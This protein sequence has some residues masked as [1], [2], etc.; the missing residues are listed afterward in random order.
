[1]GI[2][3]QYLTLIKV[4]PTLP[5][6]KVLEIME[7]KY[8]VCGECLHGIATSYGRAVS[9]F[10]GGLMG[11]FPHCAGMCSPFVLAQAGSDFSVRKLS[12]SLLLPYH[13]GR[14][15]TYVALAVLVSSFVNLAFVFSDLKSLIAVPMLV[16]AG[17]IFMV[18]IFPRTSALFP[19]IGKI[20]WNAP[21]TIV[22]KFMPKFINRDNIF[23]RYALGI[24]LGFMP[25]G[26]V[27]AALMASATAPTVLQAALAMAAFTV[28]TMPALLLVGLGGGA[29]KKK[30]PKAAR[31]FSEVAMAISSIW[32]F[33]IA[34]IMIFK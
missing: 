19:W 7:G 10:L 11:G 34:G 2:D 21:F 13:L 23:F 1:M 30:F 27:I 29:I 4:I 16:T 15:T 28:G 3:H 6:I 25:C 20:H 12:T 9:L 24:L 31:R 32:L 22:G 14:M 17:V 8:S 18:S 33:V 5:P 26:L